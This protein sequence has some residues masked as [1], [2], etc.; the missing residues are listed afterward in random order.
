MLMNG[1]PGYHNI[2]GL[3]CHQ[4]IHTV[5]VKKDDVSFN[6]IDPTNGATSE[7]YNCLY[8]VSPV[9]GIPYGHDLFL[10]YRNDWFC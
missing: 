10:S 5:A 9:T 6:P 1:H 2:I 4:S 7:Y 8:A 3:N